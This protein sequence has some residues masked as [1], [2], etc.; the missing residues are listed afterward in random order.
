MDAYGQVI[1]TILASGADDKGFFDYF[2]EGARQ[3]RGASWGRVSPCNNKQKSV[4]FNG[5]NEYWVCQYVSTPNSC[6]P[7]ECIF[8]VEPSGRVT[9][10]ETGIPDTDT[11]RLATPHLWTALGDFLCIP[12]S[13]SQKQQLADFVKQQSGGRFSY[14]EHCHDIRSYSLG[15]SASLQEIATMLSVEIQR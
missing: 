9:L 13:S 6:G 11:Y 12:V 15:R 5:N 4:V 7:F 3:L 2:V 10:V 8:H 1:E 14:E